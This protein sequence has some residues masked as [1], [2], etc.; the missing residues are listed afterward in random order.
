MFV[1]FVLLLL[2]LLLLLFLLLLLLFLLLRFL[3]MKGI[4][5]CVFGQSVALVLGFHLSI[6]PW[7]W[8][9]T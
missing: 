6:P 1:Y 2:L 8:V 7:S 3:L 4:I 5:C 9:G